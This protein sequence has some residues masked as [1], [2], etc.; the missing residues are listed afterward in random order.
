MGTMILRTLHTDIRHKAEWY[1]LRPTGLSLLRMCFSDASMAQIL[2]RAMRFCQTHK[3]GI[4]AFLLYRWNAVWNGAVIGRG[5]EFGPGFVLLHSVGVVI[6]SEVRAGR[7]LVLEHGVTIGA[8]KG[9]SPILAI[10]SLWA[11]APRSSAQCASDR[12]SR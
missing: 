9:A 3:L 6:N 4:F 10:M 12:T 11:R 5:A 2:Y 7:N 8:E 1:G